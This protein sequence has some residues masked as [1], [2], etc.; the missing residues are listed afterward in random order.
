MLQKFNDRWDG[1][2]GQ[3]NA[4]KHHIDL[5]LVGVRPLHSAPYRAGPCRWNRMRGNQQNEMMHV[6][7]PAKT[8]WP[9]PIILG[10]KKDGVLCFCI[11]YWKIYAII[12][13]HSYSLL[14]MDRWIDLLGKEQ[15]FSTGH[16]SSGYRHIEVDD[17]N[18]DKSALP[19]RNG[20]SRFIYMHFVLNN[21]VATYQ[22]VMDVIRL[23]VKWQFV[24]LYLHDIMVFLN[25]PSK[26]V[27]DVCQ[28]LYLS[29]HPGVTLKVKKCISFAHI[30]DYLG[31]VTGPSKLKLA[32]NTSN[33]IR[34]LN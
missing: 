21:A 2:L 7:E 25:S 12:I 26:H 28:V 1:Q 24:L 32:T 31:H 4:V 13:N 33:A 29:L 27:E 34:D 17:E 16:V 22:R 3:T 5:I 23:T 15:L 6:T 9:V 10:P 11:D 20:L 8:D 14:S 19:S 30:I 18:R